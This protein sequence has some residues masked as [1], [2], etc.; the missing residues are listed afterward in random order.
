VISVNLLP[1][2]ERVPESRLVTAPRWKVLLPFIVGAA[3][4]FPL[5]GV[6]LMQQARI[7]SLKED[8]SR[9]EVEKARLAPQVKAVQELASRQAEMR[10]RLRALRTLG[11][12]RS[13]MV[14]IID[15]VGLHV[16]E[17]LWLTELTS[18]GPASFSLKGATFSNLLVADL[19]G[20][21]ETSDLFFGVDL[22]ETKRDLIGAEPVIRF[23]ITFGSGPDP[24][25][26]ET[27]ATAS[28]GPAAGYNYQRGGS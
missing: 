19:M 15:E 25:T 5:G 1:Q 27:P 3:V 23:A 8:I 26:P 16:P 9:A 17:N 13:R 6:F 18:T 4:L 2:E 21:L 24:V 12:D 10:D 22:A 11:R 20:R 28:A 14:E 7:Q